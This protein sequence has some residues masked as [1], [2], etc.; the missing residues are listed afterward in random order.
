MLR[1][2][3]SGRKRIA[4]DE[5]NRSKKRLKER[6]DEILVKNLS[7]MTRETEEREKRLRGDLELHRSQQKQTLGLSIQ[8]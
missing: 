8:G 3:A 4:T 5:L 1:E 7:L 2:K 6:K